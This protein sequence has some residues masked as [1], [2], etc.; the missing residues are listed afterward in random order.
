VADPTARQKRPTAPTGAPAGRLRGG[1]GGAG[2]LGA[3]GGGLP[4]F[5]ASPLRDGG[6]DI[7]DYCAVLPE[8]GTLPDFTELV[9]QAHARGLRVITDLVMNH[10]SDQHPWFQASRSDPD[11]P[12]GDFYVWSDTDQRYSDARIIFVDT[13]TSNWTFDPVRRQYYWHRF[14][15]HQPD[16]NFE[17]PDVVE[18]VFD[19]VR[20]WLDLGID[21]F[22]L[23]AVPYL[24]EEEGTNCE[25]LPRTHRLLQDLRAMVDREYPGRVLLAEANQWPK[26]VVEYFGSEEE[27]ECHMCFHFP[28]MPRIFYAMRD[29]KAAPILDILADTPRIPRSCQWGTFLRNHDELTLEMVTTEERAAMYGWDA[30]DPRMRA[31]IGIRRRLAPLLDGSRAEIELINALLLSLPG[32]PCLYYGDEIGMGD[33][34]WL[35]DRD[36]SRTPMQWTPDRNAGFSTADP[37]KLYLPVVQSLVYHYNNVNVEAQLA[38]SSSLLHWVRGMLAVRRRHP[39]FGLGDFA[40]VPA[41]NGAVLAYLRVHRPAEGE[42]GEAETVLCVNNLSST[43]QATTLQLPDHA[44]AELED[45]FG[46]AGVPQVGGDG[47]RQAFGRR[48]IDQQGLGRAAD[49]DAPHLGVQHH[50]AG[51]LQ[52]GPR[53]QIGVVQPFQVAEHR[54]LR[55]GLDTGD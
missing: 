34:I 48:P 23:D 13:E 12:Y 11:G 27:P 7:S 8:F 1:T 3:A 47:G 21:G 39:V 35:P 22:R 24:F 14:F 45:L 37:G 41:D 29:Q 2:G 46:G 54:R 10:T 38:T 19:V 5:Y 44:G 6:Y 9:S 33:N 40:A 55:L 20:F 18:A 49:G 28:V 4:P 30:P 26:D 16:L 52:I 53:M 31:N 42:D 25:N 51:D 15:S 50:G 32:S 17:N 43:P 36:A